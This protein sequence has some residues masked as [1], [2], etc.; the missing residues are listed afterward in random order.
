ML[1]CTLLPVHSTVSLEVSSNHTLV[2]YSLIFSRLETD[3]FPDGQAP[4]FLL[5]CTKAGVPIY[6]VLTVALISCITFLAAS[7]DAV[8]VFF[9]FVDLTTTGLIATYTMM[10]LVF[11]GWYRARRAQGLGNDQLYYVAPM[12]PYAAAIGLG[13]GVVAL[14][15]IGFDTF[16]P[17]SVQGFVTSYFCLPYSAILFFGWKL[18][19]GTSLVNP[20]QA[21]LISGK[22]EADE[23]CRHWEEGGI[24]ENW[25]RALAEMSFWRRIWERV[26]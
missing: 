22:K 25:K 14:I 3:A 1:T 20:A 2:P 11:V 16:S 8:E 19:K 24:E 5:K 17:F 23:E 21:D 7:N 10:I 12:N 9:W 13:C 26:W 15:F 18:I 4:K 6:C